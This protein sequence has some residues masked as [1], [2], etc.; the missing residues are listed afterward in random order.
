MCGL[1]E[2]AI[3]C[4]LL[5]EADLTLTKAL[6]LAQSIETAQKD[7]KEIHSTSVNSGTLQNESTHHVSFKKQSVCHRCLGAGHLPGACHLRSAKG[8]KYHKTG[9]ILL[10]H[11]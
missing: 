9:H 6:P 8:N 11:V 3:Q 10:K 2:E 4:R 7:L 1:L 5:A